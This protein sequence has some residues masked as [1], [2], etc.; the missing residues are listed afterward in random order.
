VASGHL[1]LIG[2][3]PNRISSAVQLCYSIIIE[4]VALAHNLGTFYLNL[5]RKFKH[6]YY[7]KDDQLR[8]FSVFWINFVPFPFADTCILL[9]PSGSVCTCGD[10]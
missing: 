1:E 10:A 2:I 7:T 6:N 8:F 4:G 3:A 9:H 5:E